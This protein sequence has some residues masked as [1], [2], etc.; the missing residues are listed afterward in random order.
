MSNRVKPDHY[1]VKT[2]LKILGCY[3]KVEC[4]D[5]IDALGLDHHTASAFEYI[6]RHKRKNG[7]EDLRKAKWRI[8][9]AI[10]AIERA[11][12]REAT[13]LPFTGLAWK[14]CALCGTC[15]DNTKPIRS[16][17]KCGTSL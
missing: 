8:E 2:R 1:V 4:A 17:W 16:C 3:V 14:H 13:P 10:G 7:V 15:N 5:V 6:W 9:R 12:E 11:E